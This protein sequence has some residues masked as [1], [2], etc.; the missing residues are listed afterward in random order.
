[1]VSFCNGFN[2]FCTRVELRICALKSDFALSKKAI[3]THK[4]LFFAKRLSVPSLFVGLIA[5]IILWGRFNWTLELTNNEAFC[6]S[7]R[8]MGN[9]PFAELE[10]TI[11]YANLTGVRA[12]CPDCHV[13]REWGQKVVRKINTEG[14]ESLTEDERQLQSFLFATVLSHYESSHYLYLRGLLPQ[15]QWDADLRMLRNTWSG[16]EISKLWTEARRDSYRESFAQEID[17]VFE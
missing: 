13:P 14:L 6:I 10:E 7:C 8:E 3:E 2:V 11:H 16:S 5:G 1:M 9:K 15:E 4:S 17:K 12:T